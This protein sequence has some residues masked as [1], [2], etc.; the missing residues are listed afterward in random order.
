MLQEKLGLSTRQMNTIGGAVFAYLFYRITQRELI[1]FIDN[2]EISKKIIKILR[3]NEEGWILK[4]CKLYA[5]ASYKS[6][7]KVR[8]PDPLEYEVPVIDSKFLSKLNLTHLDL[9][10]PNFTIKQ[11]DKIISDIIFGSKIE[12]YIGKFISKKHLFL[13]K[14]Y[15]I[16]RDD[17]KA[18]MQTN[19][20]RAVYMH[21][22]RFESRLHFENVVK[23]AIHNSGHSLI[24]EYTA[25]K[26]Q[27]LH[28]IKVNG[29][30][31]PE[32]RHIELTTISNKLEAPISNLEQ[33][34]ESLEVLDKLSHKM[35]PEVKRFL[36]VC[37]GLYDS[38]F[39]EFLG[40]DN[41]DL[42]DRIS[43]ARY[44]SKSR[45]FF[46]FSEQQVDKFFNKLKSNLL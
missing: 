17:I 21:Y 6:K 11:Y 26:R 4:N 19:A 46:Q 20:I 45:K 27:R 8:K 33:I 13:I 15:G 39:S 2:K 24:S 28:T 3:Q 16:T 22:P 12:T 10:F 40:E 35:R 25:D 36:M 31:V 37:A 23:A 41:S 30:T 14:S 1:N 44:L 29:E 18:E 42:V 34:R 38:E 32:S 7:T 43:Y 9:K 5:W